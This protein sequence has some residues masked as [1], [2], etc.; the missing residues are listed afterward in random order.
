MAA[1]PANSFFYLVTGVHGLHVVGGLVALAGQLPW[2]WPAPAEAALSQVSN[3][4][5]STGTS[6]LAFG[7]CSSLLLA[8]GSGDFLVICRQVLT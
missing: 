7:Y 4:A 3:C 1:N 8:A 6:C 2:L 5:L